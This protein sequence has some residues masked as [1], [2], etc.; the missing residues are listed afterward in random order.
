MR[1]TNQNIPM[2]RYVNS[3]R[4]TCDFFTANATLKVTGFR[5]HNYTMSFEIAYIKI[6][7]CENLKKMF[8]YF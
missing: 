7:A 6:V 2:I 5:K 1:I 4:E 8:I 3:V